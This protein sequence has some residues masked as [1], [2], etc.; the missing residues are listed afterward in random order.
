MKQLLIS[1]F[2][3]LVLSCAQS[4]A[5]SPEFKEQITK[6]FTLSGNASASTL[7][8]YN[9]QGLIQVEAT[10]GNTVSF[11]VDKQITGKEQAAVDRGR[12]ELK[13]AFE[14][15][16]DTIFAYIA[17]PFDSRPSREN[18]R[19]N[20]SEDVPYD[21]TLAFTVRVPR[22]MNLRVSTI[23]RGDVTVN[24]MAGALRLQNVNGAIRVTNARGVTHAHTVN[25]NVD[26]NYVSNP[27]EASSYYTL[28]GNIR[29]TFPDNLAA[30]LQ[31]KTFQGEFFTDFPEIRILPVQVVKNQENRGDK[32]VY[33]LSQ[34]TQ[35]RVG[36]GGKVH[37]FE[38]FNGNV[39]IKKQS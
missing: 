26:I 5:Q 7:V 17:E 20:N 31:F 12:Q 25:G 29:V 23:N 38:T 19:K 1:V 10:S 34:T 30:D 8:I 36:N 32:T 18:W 3:G 28:N 11:R 13:L 9:I 6:D 4:S 35:V 14:Q 15:Q 22:E 27:P 33:K 16:D 2:A 37:R 21:F 39:Y 24:D